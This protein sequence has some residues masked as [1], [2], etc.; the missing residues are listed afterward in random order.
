MIEW[1]LRML[2]RADR[3]ASSDVRAEPVDQRLRITHRPSDAPDG[4]RVAQ[5]VRRQCLACVNVLHAEKVGAWMVR[6]ISASNGG[7]P[8]VRVYAIAF[9][10]KRR[11]DSLEHAP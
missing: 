5:G 1:T 9:S 4:R 2:N 6:A 8:L 3:Q 11:D 7:Q 10:P